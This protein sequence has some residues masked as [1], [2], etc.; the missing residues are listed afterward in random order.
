[1]LD[2]NDLIETTSHVSLEANN[3]PITA[4][5]TRLTPLAKAISEIN[6]VSFEDYF[7]K[8]KNVEKIILKIQALKPIFESKIGKIIE[9]RDLGRI[10][11]MLSEI[12]S[13]LSSML[14]VETAT[15]QIIPG[16]EIRTIPVGVGRLDLTS[17][18][19]MTDREAMNEFNA[20]TVDANGVHYKHPEGKHM[21]IYMGSTLFANPEMKAEFITAL[22][23]REIGKSFLN[24]TYGYSIQAQRCM[25]AI[26]ETVNI[27]Q[28]IEGMVLRAKH[29]K[30]F[31][32]QYDLKVM[33]Q[34]MKDHPVTDDMDPDDLQLWNELLVDL[35]KESVGV[36]MFIRNV[37]NFVIGIPKFFSKLLLKTKETSELERQTRGKELLG[38]KVESEDECRN[39]VWVII[40][41]VFQVFDM[42]QL[43]K[44]SGFTTFQKIMF[45][46]P[47]N[48][49]M[50]NNLI[51]GTGADKFPGYYGLGVEFTHALLIY[52]KITKA[53]DSEKNGI[54]KPFK[55][56]P[57]LNVVT[58]LPLLLTSTIDAMSSGELTTRMKVVRMY[59]QL[60]KELRSNDLNPKLR[61]DLESQLK[62]IGEVYE[63]YID[64]S[65]QNEEGN[66]ARSFMYYI[67]R[68]FLK[69]KKSNVKSPDRTVSTLVAVDTLKRSKDISKVLKMN[70][71]TEVALLSAVEKTAALTVESSDPF[72]KEF[73]LKPHFEDLSVYE[74][75]KN[76]SFENYFG[77]TPIV[78]KSIK[79]VHEIRDIFPKMKGKLTDIQKVSFKAILQTWANELAVEFNAESCYIGVEDVYNAYAYP[80][81]VG[82]RKEI[83]QQAK[84]KVLETSTGYKFEKK[85]GVQI[86]ISLGIQLLTDIALSDELIVAILFHEIGHGFQQFEGLNIRKA[87]A[88]SIYSSFI[89]YLKSF[90][91]TF[92]KAKI[93]TAIG[94]VFSLIG[95]LFTGFGFSKARKDYQ[96][97]LDAET[98]K[99]LDNI[100]N[101]S[102]NYVIVGENENFIA[103]L[104]SLV[105][106]LILTV[107]TYIP[108]PGISSFV[109][110]VAKDPLIL[111]DL[112]FRGRYF[113]RQKKNEKFADS[114]ATKYGLGAD[115]SLFMQ[116]LYEQSFNGAT[117]IPLLRTI[118]QFNMYGTI[119]M[120][121]MV[122]DHPSERARVENM[123]NTLQKELVNNKDLP[124]TMR[125]KIQSEIDDIKSV[126]C[127]M[128]SAGANFKNG[129]SGVGIIMW[130]F[131]TFMKLK[132]NV[133]SVEEFCSPVSTT[134][135]AAFKAAVSAF[136]SEPQISSLIGQTEDDLNQYLTE[137]KLAEDLLISS[138]F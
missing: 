37:I 76:V 73:E 99:T 24:F 120:L 45:A 33:W 69:L 133:K 102:T 26:E 46:N 130:I 81:S 70:S 51:N 68:Y 54:A 117:K 71:K 43:F 88:Y 38:M 124:Q 62:Q 39:A 11:P 105:Q 135:A 21:I 114:F 113:S 25:N 84:N 128:T 36:T 66:S 8:N 118:E 74:S 134:K 6:E 44:L 40:G 48:F 89:G 83:A 32:D 103:G 72:S 93:F 100:E 85:D 31:V 3:L 78:K 18:S 79:H 56:I 90:L 119:A 80:M 28:T 7:G 107:F 108:L 42:V 92:G 65:K 131:Q 77:Q 60:E 49:S 23:F 75:I 136:K 58:Q 12:D 86:I 94:M 57:G 15:I 112:A 29:F 95:N 50:M 20:Y 61:K 14:N 82:T 132:E 27:T 47:F 104:I 91:Y 116:R 5:T 121:E 41:Q 17:Y 87:K 129:R 4:E 125:L 53:R 123:Y 109:C 137:Q 55:K 9:T 35:G 63:K 138:A 106:N 52:D 126:Y 98:T 59:K 127:E 115:L 19:G 67:F 122:D 111:V 22:L 34:W 101:P 13:I 16:S 1:M 110:T 64:P 10:D 97:D 30:D 2:L 96:N